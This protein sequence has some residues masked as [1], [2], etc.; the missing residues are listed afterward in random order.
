MT[1]SH[2]HTL[3]FLSLLIWHCCALVVRPAASTYATTLNA[4]TFSPCLSLPPSLPAAVSTPFTC[5]SLLPVCLRSFEPCGLI[6]L[7]AMQYGTVPVVSSTG[8]LVD[9]VKEG[10]TGFH[11]GAFDPDRLNP[12]DADAIAA[13][14]RRAAQVFPTPKF[15]EMVRACINQDLSWSKPARKWEAVIEELTTGCKAAPA[16][17]ASV[18]TP[19][20]AKQAVTV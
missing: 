19:V 2:P 9:T 12:A 7:H 4:P 20:Q 15:K 1:Y 8:G 10:T 6:Q 17:K 18:P 14:V 13:T 5:G 16:K 11:M 3:C